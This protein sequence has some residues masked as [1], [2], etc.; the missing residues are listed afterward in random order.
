M[1]RQEIHVVVVG[2]SLAG[3]AAAA[4]LGQA[5]IGVTI[6]DKMR[7]PRRKPCG[8]GLCSIGIRALAKLGLQI[9][10]G[11]EECWPYAAYE[12]EAKGREFRVQAPWGGV[13]MQRYILDARLLAHAKG[14]ASVR[15]L[16]G[17]RAEV[18][19]DSKVQVDSQ[20]LHADFLIV[21]DGACSPIA[22]QL[23][24]KEIRYGR[25][26]NSASAMY[27]G[28]FSHSGDSIKVTVGDG[29]ELYGTRV[30][31]DLLNLSLLVPV[32]KRNIL[33]K[34]AVAIRPFFERCG[35]TD[36]MFKRLGFS[37]ELVT[38]VE[39]RAGIGNLRRELFSDRVILVGDA[40][41]EF[42]PCGGM[43]MAHAIM[44]GISAGE[45][46]LKIMARRDSCLTKNSPSVK[47]RRFSSSMRNFT[48]LSKTGMYTARKFPW[49][50]GMINNQ[51]VRKTLLAVTKGL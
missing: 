4:I 27:R 19:S 13:G 24:A 12:I 32:S 2:G 40:K 46:V 45:R 9:D 42:D 36:A 21:A 26:L 23:G 31:R 15:L 7:F 33:G 41:E 18:L 30:G 3:A 20:L 37:G 48:R 49:L 28:E 47:E 29:F 34:H 43:G 10:S 16:E 50:F 25:V 5:G 8:E 39:G 35:E 1:D 44:S 17:H 11:N 6:V 51:I 38:P 14:F 22:R